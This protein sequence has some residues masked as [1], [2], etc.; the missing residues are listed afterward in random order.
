MCVCVK[1]CVCERETPVTATLL[2]LQGMTDEGYMEQD[3]RVCVS[4]HACVYVC[5][6][7]DSKVF[8]THSFPLSGAERSPWQ[9]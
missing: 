4:V 8:H 9:H 2:T 6:P 7:A 5:V 3:Q 1:V